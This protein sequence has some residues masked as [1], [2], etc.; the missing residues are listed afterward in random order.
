MSGRCS[1]RCGRQVWKDNQCHIHPDGILGS[2]FGDK[3][4]NGILEVVDRSQDR[5]AM[6]SSKAVIVRFLGGYLW[7]NQIYSWIPYLLVLWIQPCSNKGCTGLLLNSKGRAPRMTCLA[8]FGFFIPTNPSEI[9]SHQKPNIQ[10]TVPIKSVSC[11]EM[12]SY[13]QEAAA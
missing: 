6:S 13:W 10:K 2:Y 11:P 12:I 9:E 5:L 3:N 7:H 1:T 4:Q 8:L